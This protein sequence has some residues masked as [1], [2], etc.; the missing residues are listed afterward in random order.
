MNN[1]D[2]KIKF[3][4]KSKMTACRCWICNVK[5]PRNTNMATFKSGN[6]YINICLTH[7]NISNCNICKNQ[8]ICVTNENKSICIDGHK[9]S[10]QFPNNC[11]VNYGPKL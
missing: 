11:I 5:I 3:L 4:W 1:L 6:H 9:I 8:Y 10:S 2:I 7:F